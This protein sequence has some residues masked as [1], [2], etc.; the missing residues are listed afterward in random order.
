MASLALVVLFALKAE[1]AAVGADETA[2]P[3][4]FRFVAIG[5]VQAACGVA[6]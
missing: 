2:R 1:N 4:D 5:A 3:I 6:K